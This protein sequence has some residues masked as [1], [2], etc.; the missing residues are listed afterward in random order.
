MG[1]GTYNPII[2]VFQQTPADWPLIKIKPITPEEIVR[3]YIRFFDPDLLVACGKVANDASK[4]A[5]AGR[6]VLPASDITQSITT[7]GIPGYGVGLY[8]IL[9]EL[10]R[11]EFK[12]V[13]RDNLKVLAPTFDSPTEPFLA[14][15]FGNVPPDAGEEIYEHFLRPV[16]AYRP[17]VTMENFL[18]FLPGQYLF[19]R[20]VCGF[21]IDVRRYRADRS[22]V[23]F[24][25][26][27]SN[28][29]DLIDYWNLRAV[30]WEVLPIPKAISGSDK[31]KEIG[32]KFIADN[33]RRDA[34]TPS[35]EY[36]VTIVKGRSLGE[37]D[38]SAFVDSLRETPEQIMTCQFWYPSMWDEFTQARGHL[39]CSQ[40]VA[41][42]R[43]AQISD[44]DSA[45]RVATLAPA[46]MEVGYRS[47]PSYANDVE[48]DRYG[49][50]EFGTEVIPPDQET[51]ARLF[52][53]G[54][55]DEWRAGSN[56]LTFLGRHAESVTYLNQP[57]P[58][59][60]AAS[61]LEARGWTDFKTS[62]AGHVAYQMMRHL[63]GPTGI[64]LLKSQRLIEYLEKL[65][66]TN[67]HD[68]A[69][70]FFAEVK[71]IDADRPM[72]GGLHRRVQLYTDAKIFTLGL[73]VQCSVCTQRSWHALDSASYEV[74]CP[75]CLS[76]FKL[77]IH[78]PAGE[79]KWSY[80]NLGPFTTPPDDDSSPF[81][82][83]WAYKSLG[84]FAAQKR[85]GGAYSVLLTASFLCSYHHPATTTV[86]SFVA[87]G[88]DGKD[89]EADFM[90]FCN[91]PGQAAWLKPL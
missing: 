86:L 78:N 31:A 22:A 61:V 13:R 72:H 32:R 77:P 82:L 85:G 20:E 14:A 46:F 56:G 47:G 66:R 48:I 54:M 52:G 91:W 10:G 9:A 19:R 12:F 24:H 68:L 15:I 39:T 11:Q 33:E 62:P 81:E 3:G 84:P 64:N 7:R 79:L 18:D 5:N 2:P 51:V 36:R 65:S 90:M 40:L 17:A 59:A 27:H 42:E 80:K 4:L 63:G 16:D 76:R 75:R 25:F 23:I 35:F 50:K 34:E 38:H 87:K 43:T 58:V 83:E 45:L 30:G 88:K 21:K 29:L 67:G 69:Q 60:V 49:L 28:A 8:E 55:P 73:E 1:G 44:E 37:T 41:D 53:L 70:A 26:D 89:L 74:Q 6:T 57:N 71:K